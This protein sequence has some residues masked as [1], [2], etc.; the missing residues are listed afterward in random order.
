MNVLTKC[1]IK[2][3]IKSIQ[4]LG[5]RDSGCRNYYYYYYYYYDLVQ[6]LV[7]VFLKLICHFPC[8]YELEYTMKNDIFW[9]A[10]P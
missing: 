6:I 3:R 7:T 4:V 8:P 10:T 9:D 5:E 1:V 2:S